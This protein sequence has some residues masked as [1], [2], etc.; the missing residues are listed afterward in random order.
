M[1]LPE[2]PTNVRVRRQDGS[3]VAVEVRYAGQD[4]RGIHLWIATMPLVLADDARQFGLHV[5]LFPP[6]TA[7]EV[8]VV[9]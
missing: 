7:I 2:A 3:S 1:S 5:D 6:R 9:W 8:E 4:D